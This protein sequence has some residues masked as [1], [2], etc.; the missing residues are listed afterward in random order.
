MQSKGVGG[1]SVIHTG[2]DGKTL[3]C[4][5]IEEEW[6]E[7]HA[8]GNFAGKPGGAPEGDASTVLK[9][10]KPRVLVDYITKGVE[11]LKSFPAED[12]FPEGSFHIQ[13]TADGCLETVAECKGSPTVPRIVV[14][15]LKE[16]VAK[17]R[18]RKG[19]SYDAV[20]VDLLRMIR[21]E[22]NILSIG[23]PGRSAPRIRRP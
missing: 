19:L 2:P 10:G 11:E 16:L 17:N 7:A 4:L 14:L 1:Q 12:L 8:G 5:R 18:I 13:I 22:K 3:P 15:S 6:D 20:V 23:D 9:S 21:G